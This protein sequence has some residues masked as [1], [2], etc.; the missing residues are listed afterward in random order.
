MVDVVTQ[1]P[2]IISGKGTTWPYLVV[3]VPQLPAVQQLLDAH[4]IPYYV[5]EHFISWNGGPEEAT[6]TFGRGADAEAI[7]TVLESV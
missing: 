4:A 3:T 7:Q 1:K 5:R 6:V 2:L